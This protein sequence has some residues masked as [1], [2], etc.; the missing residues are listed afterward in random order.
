MKNQENELLA[1]FAKINK[2]NEVKKRLL[3]YE[4]DTKI[5]LLLLEL[6]T[7]KRL[8]PKLFEK[9]ELINNPLHTTKTSE[10]K[11]A[12]ITLSTFANSNLKIL[13]DIEDE[14]QQKARNK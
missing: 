2:N 5:K 3:Q 4:Q 1:L 7:F 12:M 14:L 9:I 10:W 6:S 13:D 11:K 8:L